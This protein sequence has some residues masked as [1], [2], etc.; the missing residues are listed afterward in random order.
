MSTS[1]VLTDVWFGVDV[2]MRKNDLATRVKGEGH[3][4]LRIAELSGNLFNYELAVTPLRNRRGVI[5]PLQF[6]F[7]SATL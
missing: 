2:R 7:V 4:T 5:F 3:R 1:F 6:V